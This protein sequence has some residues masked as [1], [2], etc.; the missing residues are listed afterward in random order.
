WGGPG[1]GLPAGIGVAG[2]VD[3]DGVLRTGP[4]LPGFT[5]YPFAARLAGR[6]RGPVAGE[7]DATAPARAEQQVGAAR[8]ADDPLVVALG[9]GIGGAAVV[10]G[11]LRRGAHGFA[12]EFG[13]MV[14]DPAGP[15]CPCGA[16]GCWERFAS[17]S[18]LERLADRHPSGRFRG[19]RGE[20]VSA[21]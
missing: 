21:A 5:G 16:D 3:R 7:N 10:G 19:A 2:L 4:N 1:S 14:V 9:T 8:G 12:G 6:T 20:E 17:G 15:R 18:G 13:H 11:A